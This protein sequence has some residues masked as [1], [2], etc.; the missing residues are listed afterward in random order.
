MIN[1]GIW[2]RVDGLSKNASMIITCWPNRTRAFRRWMDMC[3]RGLRKELRNLRGA[4]L[5]TGNKESAKDVSSC[6]RPLAPNYA[7]NCK[8]VY[9]GQKKRTLTKIEESNAHLVDSGSERSEE[10]DGEERGDLQRQG[11]LLVVLERHILQSP[12]SNIP[13]CKHKPYK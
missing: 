2:E 9:G 3:N 11:T 10:A 1:K 4:G 6:V 5:L 12:N 7:K 13:I 8:E